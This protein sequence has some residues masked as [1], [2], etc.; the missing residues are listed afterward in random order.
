MTESVSTPVGNAVEKLERTAHEYDERWDSSLA[1]AWERVIPPRK[2]LVLLG[3]VRRAN[4]MVEGLRDVTLFDSEVA[5][6]EVAVCCGERVQW[7][8][9]LTHRTVA[10]SEDCVLVAAQRALDEFA[11]GAS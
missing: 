7:D 10:H 1:S 8:E 4:A 6:D 11:E 9:R 5:P 2:L 3:I